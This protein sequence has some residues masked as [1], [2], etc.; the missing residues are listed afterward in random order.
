MTGIDGD[1]HDGTERTDRSPGVLVL[2]VYLLS[3]AVAGTVL[4]MAVV[5]VAEWSQLFT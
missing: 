4:A 2:G 3:A 5:K 1:T